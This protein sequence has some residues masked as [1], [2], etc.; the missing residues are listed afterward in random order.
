M[1]TASKTRHVFILFLA[2]IVW[3]IAFVAQSKGGDAV[4]AFSFNGIR[5][6]IGAL[7]LLPVIKILDKK[8]LTVNR[9][10]SKKQKKELG[11]CIVMIFT[12]MGPSTGGIAQWAQSLCTWDAWIPILYAGIFSSGVGYTLQIVGQKGLNPA[13]A[14][15][16]MSLE[17]VVSVIAGWIL[18]GQ[19]LGG[20]EIFGCVLMFIA[21]II[22]QLPDREY[23]K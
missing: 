21:I 13:V 9:P 20:R 17:S 16:A 14:S 10:E 5:F 15:V 6:L 23:T 22:A 18:L 1:N 2:D 8:E 4:G 11:S 19:M 12:D 3:G 7:C